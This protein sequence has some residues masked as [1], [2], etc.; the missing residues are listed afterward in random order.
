M[1]SEAYF[2]FAIGNLKPIFKVG[3]TGCMT[4]VGWPVQSEWPMHYSCLQD[5]LTRMGLGLQCRCD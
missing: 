5:S 3:G 1:Y 2:V 4:G